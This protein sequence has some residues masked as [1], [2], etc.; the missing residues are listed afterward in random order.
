[1]TRSSP[2]SPASRSGS[3]GPRGETPIRRARCGR[4][5][6]SRLSTTAAAHHTHDSAGAKLWVCC[7]GQILARR[8]R[9]C[10]VDKA[11]RPTYVSRRYISGT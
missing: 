2:L 11:K 3:M 4:S 10:G 1:V 9:R 7:R 6:C 8:D 5:R